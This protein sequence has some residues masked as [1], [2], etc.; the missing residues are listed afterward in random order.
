MI[1]SDI[2]FGDSSMVEKTGRHM[3]KSILRGELSRRG[4]SYA[5]LAERL[6]TFGIKVDRRTLTNKIGR[7]SFTAAFFVRC[8]E[9]IGATTIHLDNG[10]V[11]HRM[12]PGLS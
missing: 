5:D 8:L 9:A 4:I 10:Q 11:K 12:K 2:K 7:G 3:V 6:V 1:S